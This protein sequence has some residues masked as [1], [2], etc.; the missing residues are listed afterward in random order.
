ML[1]LSNQSKNY[2]KYIK[3]L[4][5]LGLLAQ[6]L[7]NKPQSSKQ[8]YITTKKGSDFLIRVTKSSN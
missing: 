7:P 6:T 3:P 4:L 2:Q 5:D 8:Q 1:R